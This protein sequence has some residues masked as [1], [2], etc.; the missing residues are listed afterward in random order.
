MTKIHVSRVIGI[1][2]AGL[3]AFAPALSASAERSS[4]DRSSVSKS[5]HQKAER[6]S[7]R[8]RRD[9]SSRKQT[10]SETRRKDRRERAR[11]TRKSDRKR[12][13]RR[14]S[15]ADQQR[16]ERAQR[17]RR[18]RTRSERAQQPAARSVDSRQTLSS[19]DLVEKP[20]A[21]RNEDRVVGGPDLT[22]L[23][24][25]PSAQDRV[26]GAGL[27]GV[28]DAL[29]K[30]VVDAAGR[31]REQLADLQHGPIGDRFGQPGTGSTPGTGVGSGMGHTNVHGEP[32]TEGLAGGGK[33]LD[34]GISDRANVGD[35]IVN[36]SIKGL[37]AGAAVAGAAGNV[38]VAQGLAAAAGGLQIGQVIDASHKAVYGGT[39]GDLAGWV[40]DK[41][42]VDSTEETEAKG[43][44]AREAGEER[45]K[46]KQ[47]EEAKKKQEEEE[48]KKQ[49]EEDEEDDD[50]D[51]D[52]D[53]DSTDDGTTDD[54]TTPNPMDDNF[55]ARNELPARSP[56]ADSNKEYAPGEGEVQLTEQ[57]VAELMAYA[58]AEANARLE[59]QIN[60]GDNV[61]GEAT[62][63]PDVDECILDG[64]HCQPDTVTTG[65]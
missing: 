56:M 2:L 30:D 7:S 1:L 48:K 55:G 62:G 39:I 11:A 52:E 51:S 61:E 20:R 17:T 6:R 12:S 42:T 37:T 32:G 40:W 58:Q 4:R 31:G 43:K 45:K 65:Q 14:A 9:V 59:S 49:E 27:P 3:L 41:A 23:A 47:E 10:K 24:D 64:A 33:P 35:D 46:K 50:T 28:S 38:P 60:M 15:A 26:G 34:S 54:G 57:E 22:N 44:A 18:D 19:R 63:T 53:D 5:S 25:R 36:Q 8:S 16:A 13:E 29:T 21:P